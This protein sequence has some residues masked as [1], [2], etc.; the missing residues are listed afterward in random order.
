MGKVFTK[1]QTRK[2][3]RKKLVKR[4]REQLALETCENHSVVAE[5]D[6]EEKRI[7]MVREKHRKTQPLPQIAESLIGERGL[8]RVNTLR[9]VESAITNDW[10]VTPEIRQDVVSAVHNVVTAPDTR[11]GTLLKAS[12]VLLLADSINAGREKTA[13]GNG[14]TTINLSIGA[15]PVQERQNRLS[16]MAARLGIIDTTATPTP[17]Q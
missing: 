6:T 8:V 17:E 4:L 11:V 9:M 15:A 5:S 16:A 14:A 1:T 13:A 12:R 2:D 10:P 7:R 3:R